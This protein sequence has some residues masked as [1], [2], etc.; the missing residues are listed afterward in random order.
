MYLL[1]VD[2]DC[3]I[4]CSGSSVGVFESHRGCEDVSPAVGLLWESLRVTVDVKMYLL[5]VDVDCSISCSGSS[6][7]VLENHRGCEDVSPAGGCGDVVSPAVGVLESHRGC[8]DVSP[9][10]GLLCESSRI[11]VD[12]EMYLLQWVF[13]GSPR[14]SPWM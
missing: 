4:S 3:S 9:A 11:T 6:V 8:E 14:E 2:V 7:G 1:Q 13:C 10:V 5:Q 12:V